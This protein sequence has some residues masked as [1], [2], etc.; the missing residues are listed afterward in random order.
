MD[1]LRVPRVDLL[2]PSVEPSD[3]EFELLLESAIQRVLAERE[4]AVLRFGEAFA[5][6]L[7]AVGKSMPPRERPVRGSC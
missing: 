3:E 5:E 7:D 1:A 4:R 2:D 6:E